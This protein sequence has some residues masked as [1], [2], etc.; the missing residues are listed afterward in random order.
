MCYRKY[1]RNIAFKTIRI[2]KSGSLRRFKPDDYQGEGSRVRVVLKDILNEMIQ[3][4]MAGFKKTVP[5]RKGPYN[6]ISGAKQGFE[7]GLK[8]GL[9]SEL[10]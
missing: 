4:S 8:K 7:S 6:T 9:K 1:F 5:I 3:G 2:F 10:K